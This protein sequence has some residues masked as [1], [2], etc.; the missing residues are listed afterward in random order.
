MVLLL[1]PPPP[2][3]PEEE[4]CELDALLLEELDVVALVSA[5]AVVVDSVVADDELVFDEDATGFKTVVLD[6][7]DEIALINMAHFSLRIQPVLIHLSTST[8]VIF[9]MR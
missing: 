5:V 1:P 6:V 9:T 3:P 2:P 4:L 7:S 8:F